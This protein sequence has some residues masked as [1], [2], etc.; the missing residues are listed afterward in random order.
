MKVEFCSSTKLRGVA[1]KGRSLA[2]EPWM[3]FGTSS[4]RRPSARAAAS[5]AGR[6]VA[7][8]EMIFLRNL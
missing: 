6:F 5:D 4:T 2:I 1:T 8:D 7:R 3:E